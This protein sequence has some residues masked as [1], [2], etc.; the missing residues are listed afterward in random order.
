M[1]LEHRRA[2]LLNRRA[3][4]LGV[5]ALKQALEFRLQD[6]EIAAVARFL[7]AILERF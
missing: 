3:R 2:A 5:F 6:R 1:S 7:N 4:L